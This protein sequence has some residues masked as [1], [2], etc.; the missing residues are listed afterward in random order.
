MPP[1]ISIKDS[2]KN[3]ELRDYFA[4]H[5]V[6]VSPVAHNIPKSQLK[7]LAKNAYRMADAMIE[8]RQEDLDKD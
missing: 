1:K 7:V 6:S 3:K 4:A 2:Q 8:A 5:I